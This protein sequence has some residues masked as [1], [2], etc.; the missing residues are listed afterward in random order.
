MSQAQGQAQVQAQ[1]QAINGAAKPERA[2][3][4]SSSVQAWAGEDIDEQCKSPELIAAYHDWQAHAAKGLPRLSEMPGS[5]SQTALSNAVLVLKQGDDFLVVHHG[6]G[7]VRR[8]GGN[9]TGLLMSEIARRSTVA[10]DLAV[11]YRACIAKARPIYVRYVS[12][13]SEEH[14]CFERILLPIAADADRAPQFV[15]SYISPMDDMVDVLKAI[16]E[17]SPIGMIAALPARGADGKMQDGRILLINPH[18]RRIL[19]LPESLD[20]INNVRDLGPWFRD[21]ALWTRTNVIAEGRQ[22]HI[23]YRDRTT[24]MNYR[25]TIEPVDRFMLFSIMEFTI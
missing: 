12:K 21:G 10:R 11:A 9:F 17:H 2:E 16:F 25:V 23:H 8:M 24:G 20:R 13:I 7:A 22:T 15:L 1:P 18:A 14:L 5:D 6:T 19:K 3:A 4:G